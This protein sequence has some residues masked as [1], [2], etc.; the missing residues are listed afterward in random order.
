MRTLVAACALLAAA[1]PAS[2]AG[3]HAALKG[4]P[5]VEFNAQDQALMRAK[6][7][8]ALAAP[9][10]SAPL[11][12]RNEATSASGSVEA[13]QPEQWRGMSCRHLRIQNTHRN[14]SAEGVYRFCERPAGQWKLA[15]PVAK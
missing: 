11:T 13:L 9:L 14:R 8:E 1:L 3:E 4:N 7:R 6:V 15:G 2:A 12:W 10:G 5:V